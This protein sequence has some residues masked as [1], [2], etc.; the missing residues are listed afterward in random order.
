MMLFNFSDMLT[1]LLSTVNFVIV[2]LL[3]TGLFHP[4]L[5]FTSMKYWFLT[6]SP[7]LLIPYLSPFTS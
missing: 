7:G 5:T 2:P 1:T 4:G 3:N 6:G